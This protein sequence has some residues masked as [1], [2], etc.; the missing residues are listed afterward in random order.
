MVEIK[1]NLV[2]EKKYN[3]KCP[4]EMEAEFVIVHNTF[5]DAPAENEIKYMIS[6]N[7]TVSFHYAVDDKE[8]VQG[9]PTNRNSWNAG[10]GGS[11]KGNRKGIAIEICYSKSGGE[12][13]IQ[14]EKNASEFIASILK[15]KGWG[16]DRVKRHKDF[17][18]KYC[19][20]RTMDM[21]WDRFLDMI[22]AHMGETTPAH[23]YKIGDNVI[24]ST[25]YV[26]STAPNSEA[27]PVE[28]MS[29]NHGTITRIVEA[30][31][32]YLLNNGLCWVND[33][34]IRGYYTDKANSN[35][36]KDLNAVVDAVIRG[37]YGNGQDR[38]SRL[39]ADGYD[40]NE[41]QR[42]VNKRYGV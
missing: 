21:G 16:I 20:H 37:D 5:N 30:K 41:I 40:P 38:I 23:K 15:E 34:D 22:K 33:G 26:S 27:I 3:I 7:N 39:K 28:K 42:L 17:S 1:K 14:A 4:Y 32:P 31:N 10:D 36:T 12:R 25:C 35:A 11:G 18:G 24:F 19:P 29:T 13:F 8:I 6:N 2:D 9:I